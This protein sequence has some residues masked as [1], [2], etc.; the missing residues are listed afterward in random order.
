MMDEDIMNAIDAHP[1][2]Q[3]RSPEEIAED[4]ARVLGYMPP[5]KRPTASEPCPDANQ[6]TR[7][8]DT[9]SP[10]ATRCQP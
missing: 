1:A 3:H 4:E 2:H 10:K 7:A 5:T 6:R 9:L 8:A